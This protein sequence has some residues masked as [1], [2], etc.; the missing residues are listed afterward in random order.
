[1]STVGG[2]HRI[3]MFIGPFVGAAVIHGNGPRAA[4]LVAVGASVA[5]VLLLL[6]VPEPPHTD[7][8]AQRPRET[9]SLA[10]VWHEHGRL[11]LSLGFAIFAVGAVRTARPVVLPLWAD[12]IGLDAKTTSLIFGISAAVDMALFYPAGRAMDRWGRIWVAL[13]SMTLLGGAMMLIPLTGGAMGLTVVAVLMGFANGLGSGIVMT[14][15]AD[16]A[17]RD[18][19]VRFLAQWR[20]MADSGHA[21]GPLLVAAVAALAGLGV[22]IVAAGVLGLLAGAGI[23]RWAPRYSPYATREMVRASQH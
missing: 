4:F 13:P 10:T 12:H 6:V 5:T 16:V 20:L 18:G 19:T 15:G 22:G 2:S 21:A 3:G 17:P 9:V 23:A 11:L 8:V 1:M 14:L 7:A